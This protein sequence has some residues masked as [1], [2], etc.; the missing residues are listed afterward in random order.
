MT[1]G[2]LSRAA[3]SPMMQRESA[4]ARGGCGGNRSRLG[5]VACS[6]D[7]CDEAQVAQSDLINRAR[8]GDEAAWETLVC[9]HQQPLFRLAYLLLGDA[10]EAEDVTQEAFV[11]AFHALDRFDLAR[12]VRPWLLRIVTN[13]ARN[14]RRALG[15]YLAALLRAGRTEPEP[16]V[17]IGERSGQQWEAQML[18]QAVRRLRYDDQ[19]IIYLRY[20]LDLSEAEAAA[21]L[22]VAPGTIKSRLHRATGRLRQVVDAE[23]PA[24][25]EGREL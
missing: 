7:R 12:P 22:A 6:N 16:V 5:G 14:R 23:F 3:A 21:V 13:L 17:T 1:H 25:R 20:F 8:Y 9:E 18:W 10:D 2:N 11:R 4:T 24:L 15:R 19:Q